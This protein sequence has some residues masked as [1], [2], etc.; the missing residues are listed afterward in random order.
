MQ[1]E[2]TRFEFFSLLERPMAIFVRWAPISSVASAYLSKVS[3]TGDISIPVGAKTFRSSKT[4]SASSRCGEIYR[5]GRLRV[6]EMWPASIGAKDPHVPSAFTGLPSGFESR[7]RE[8]ISRT[9]LSLLM[10]T[11]YIIYELSL[12]TSI[13][14]NSNIE[15]RNKFKNQK[16]K[17][18]KPYSKAV[19]E[20]GNRYNLPLAERYQSPFF[21]SCSIGGLAGLLP[22]KFFWH[23]FFR[24][25]CQLHYF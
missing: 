14:R 4:L 16:I 3:H 6:L 9:D 8:T 22:W 21:L 2:I 7:R 1:V 19:W 12:K 10:S 11:G 5:I 24:Y 25:F 13:S 15:I 18:S 17:F 20:S 23:I